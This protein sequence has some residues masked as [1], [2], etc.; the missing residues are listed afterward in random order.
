MPFTSAV[1]RADLTYLTGHV[2]AH[3]DP[4]NSMMSLDDGKTELAVVTDVSMGGS[5]ME[6]GSLELMV[7]RRC[8]A[9]DSRGVQ[10]PLNE[11]RMYDSVAHD[12]PLL[13]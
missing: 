1:F 9:D 5:S 7:H 11:V 8:Q 4:V 3:A 10:E 12:G 6:D 2:G 13:L